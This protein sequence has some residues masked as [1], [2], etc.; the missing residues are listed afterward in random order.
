MLSPRDPPQIERHTE[1]KVKEKDK[2]NGKRY[3]TQMERGKKLG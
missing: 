3:F 1:I 2:V